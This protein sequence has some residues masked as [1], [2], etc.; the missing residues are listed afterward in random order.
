MNLEEAI[1]CLESVVA[2]E[3]WMRLF[4]QLP[5]DHEVIT[6]ILD[7]AEAVQVIRDNFP[8]FTEV[9]PEDFRFQELGINIDTMW[10]FVSKDNQV[11][12][13]EACDD[14]DY[15]NLLY[16]RTYEEARDES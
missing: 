6:D 9:P 10:L 13:I 1:D 4:T 14:G 5:L 12:T 16:Y 11:I 15:M 7:F 2:G 3:V 8:N